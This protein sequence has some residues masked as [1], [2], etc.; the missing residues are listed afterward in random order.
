[1]NQPLRPAF[2]WLPALA[3]GLLAAWLPAS[4]A[5]TGPKPRPLVQPPAQHARVIVEFKSGL[6]DFRRTAQSLHG[7]SGS[8][9]A[10]SAAE[11]VQALQLRASQLG[12]RVGL[13]LQGGHA[14]NERMQVVTAEGID[15]RA[16]VQRLASDPQVAHVVVDGWRRPLRVP[17]DPYFAQGPAVVGSSGGPAAGQWY[18]KPPLVSSLTLGT[19]E[20]TEVAASIN[21]TAAWDITSGDPS[22]RVAVLDTGI[23]PDHPDLAGKIVAG[24]DMISDAKVANDGNG[25]DADPSDP[26]DW[27]TDAEANDSSSPFYHCTTPNSDGS[28][29]GESSSWHGTQTAALIGAATNNAKGIAGAGWNVSVEP[30]RVLGKCGGNDSDI[31]AGIEWAAGVN[32]PGLP[33]NPNPAK[34]LNLSLGGSGYPA[35]LCSDTAYPVAIAD[36]RAK[37]AVVVVSAG[38]GLDDG[39]HALNPPAN[40]SGV[41]AV[42]GLRHIGTK[43]GFSDLGP[44]VSIAAPAGNCVNTS[45]ACI[46]PIMSATNT[47]TQ[48]PMSSAYTDSFDAGLGTSFS[49]P[50]VSATAALMFTA[51]P[52]LSPDQL[53]QA[54]QHSARAFPQSGAA[55]D[56]NGPVPTCQAPGATGQLQCYCTTSTCGAGILDAAAA[57]AAVA[58]LTPYID[59]GPASPAAGQAVTLSS[60]TSVAASGHTIVS[61]AWALVDAGGI[62]APLTDTASS[63]ISLVST[64]AGQF[65]VQLTVVDDTGASASTKQIVKVAAASTSGGSGSGGGSSGSSS[66]GGGGGAMSVDWLAALALATLALAVVRRRG[67]AASARARGR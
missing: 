61:R 50:L 34:V 67:S 16:L 46:Y 28:Y 31:A 37:G 41:I 10:M 12:N 20:T 65:T 5:E 8:I 6:S 62:V 30:V 22:V 55:A 57:V 26:G 18:L 1:M 60:A 47:G 58:R 45:G 51:D 9:V 42:A 59:V 36:A 66:S 32:V 23:R 14:V 56:A 27:V 3:L 43:V 33:V 17:N 21:A 54:M 48:G 19:D 7:V 39:G 25:R 15:S 40:C 24:Y 2:R 11:A 13:A 63:A 53:L 35:Q 38:N 29:S 52:G 44:D 64:G 49:A 4:Q